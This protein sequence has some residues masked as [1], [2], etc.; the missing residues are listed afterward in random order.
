MLA[1][2]I[3]LSDSDLAQVFFIRHVLSEPWKLA[4]PWSQ[5]RKWQTDTDAHMQ[6]ASRMQPEEGHMGGVRVLCNTYLDA[7]ARLHP[8]LAFLP[9]SSTA[10]E[11]APIGIIRG[12]GP[13]LGLLL[14]T[15]TP[16]HATRAPARVSLT[17]KRPTG[18]C[19]VSER[20]KA[21]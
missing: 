3:H 18:G 2:H 1:A 6:A 17:I 11:K 13:V 21:D 19:A 7:W 9:C 16:Q 14:E 8:P 15:G 10:R 20:F 5:G 12:G 4:I